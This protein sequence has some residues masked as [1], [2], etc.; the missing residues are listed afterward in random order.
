M[1]LGYA[2]AGLRHITQEKGLQ[3]GNSEG[4]QVP[5]VDVYALGKS[6]TLMPYL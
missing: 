1:D 6:L 2:M 5:C 3:R 4:C